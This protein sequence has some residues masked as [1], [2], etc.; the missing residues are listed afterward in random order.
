LTKSDAVESTCFFFLA[1][2]KV[3]KYFKQLDICIT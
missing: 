1:V 2:T 3:H